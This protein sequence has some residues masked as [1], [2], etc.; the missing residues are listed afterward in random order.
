MNAASKKS[1]SSKNAPTAN[2]EAVA[3][4]CGSYPPPWIQKNGRVTN[5]SS[6][7]S[8][9]QAIVLDVV[10]A[11]TIDAKLTPGKAPPYKPHPAT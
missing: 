9:H 7:P 6:R 11:V 1:T 5:L 2:R 4:R 3:D 10:S 8:N